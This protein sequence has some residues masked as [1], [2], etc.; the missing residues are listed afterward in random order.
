MHWNLKSPSPAG[1]QGVHQGT[2]RAQNQ[3]QNPPT[4]TLPN[5]NLKLKLESK[6]NFKNKK[7]TPIQIEPKPH[8]LEQVPNFENKLDLF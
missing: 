2:L 4:H 7:R 6:L 5:L 1:Y 3:I 8:I